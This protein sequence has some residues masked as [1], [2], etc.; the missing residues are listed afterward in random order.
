MRLWDVH[1]GE[2][3]KTWEFGSAIKRVEFS[4]DGTQLLAVMEKR[5]GHLSTIYV[6][7]INTEDPAASGSEHALRI[8]V[9]DSKATVAGFSYQS[10]YIIAGHEDGTVSQFDAKV[11]AGAY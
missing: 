5:A 6:Y 1:S 4:P 3:L 10:Q 9:D 7:D 2:L 8:V 11:C